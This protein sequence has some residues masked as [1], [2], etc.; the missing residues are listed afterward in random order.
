MAEEK[1][2]REQINLVVEAREKM[3]A[4]I[5]KRTEALYSWQ[6]A[7]KQLYTN[8]SDAKTACQVAEDSLRFLALETYA[9]TGEKTVAYGIGI[10]VLTRLAY[11][12]S[13]AMSWALEHKLALKLD[14]SAFEKMVKA[15]PLSFSF[16]AISEEPSAT[17]ATELQKVE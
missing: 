9:K 15:N 4:A 13:D 14:F 6:E 2:L 7:N 12:D 17:I 3:Q 1:Q 5:T 10:R 16:V 8:E 11:E